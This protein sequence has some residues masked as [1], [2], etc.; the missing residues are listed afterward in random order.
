MKCVAVPTP[1][2]QSSDLSA[3]DLAVDSLKE[4]SVARLA[5]FVEARN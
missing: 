5:A 4:L 1:L 3:A 2:S